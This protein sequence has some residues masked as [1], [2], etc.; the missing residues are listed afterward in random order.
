VK[1][2]IDAL[3]VAVRE[4]LA[5]GL[6]IPAP[7]PAS[8]GETEVPLDPLTAARAALARVMADQRLSKVAVAQRMGKDEAQVRRIL[9][10]QGGVRIE[11]V[12]EA[13]R[14]LG[15]HPTLAV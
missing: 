10:G 8:E 9:N 15:V 5:Q 1:E 12:L 6:P 4:Y 7:R 13:L 11:G 14:A 2:A 3:G